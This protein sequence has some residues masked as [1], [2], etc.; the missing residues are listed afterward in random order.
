MK[1]YIVTYSKQY[2]AS[3]EE[4][5]MQHLKEETSKDQDLSMFWI[6]EVLI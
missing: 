6:K 2:K 1:T 5:A 3:S 4:E